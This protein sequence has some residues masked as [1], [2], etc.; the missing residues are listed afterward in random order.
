MLDRILAILSISMLV[1]FMLVVAV[2][3]NEPDLW[4]VIII[5]L[6]M[7]VFDFW[8]GLRRKRNNSGH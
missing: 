1:A 3:V 2:Y 5:V 7:A 4:I 8:S 6:T